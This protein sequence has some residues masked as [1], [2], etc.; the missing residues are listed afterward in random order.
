VGNLSCRE[1]KP[2]KAIIDIFSHHGDRQSGRKSGAQAA[3][4]PAPREPSRL[5]SSIQAEGNNKRLGLRNTS[6]TRGV[7]QRLNAFQGR[8]RANADPA[9]ICSVMANTLGSWDLG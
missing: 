2:D 4:G 1:I 5:S 8:D 3:I 6:G 7:V 9:F